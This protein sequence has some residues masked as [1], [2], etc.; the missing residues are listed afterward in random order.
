MSDWDPALYLH[1]G[2]ERTRPASEL[3][4]RVPLEE[5]AHV[6]DLGCGPGNSTALLRQ[7]WPGAQ[8][9]GVDNSPAMLAQARA[10]LP[11]CHFLE[12]DI[13]TF[14]PERALDLIYANASLQWVPD[15]YTLLPQL[16][17]FLKMSGVLAIQMPDNWQEPTHVLMREVAWEQGYP[18]RGREALPG[19]HAYYDIL[20]EA[21][22][23]VELWRTTY[24]HSMGSHQ[25]IIDWVRATGLRPWLAELNESEQAHYL[26]RY[27]QLL[28][29]QYPLQEDG[30]IL[31]AYPRLFMVARR[32]P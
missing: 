11:D 25:E 5:A 6:V 19:V 24:Y 3:L 20:S 15:H 2:T 18:D 7:R 10:A 9:T 29:E 27:H 26:R 1:Y 32:Q 31:L 22:C 16:V 23:E 30:Q 21:G 14:R 17:A 8:V 4:A 13:R 12:A 28:E